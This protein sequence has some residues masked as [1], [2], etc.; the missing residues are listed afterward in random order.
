MVVIEI[1]SIIFECI[2]IQ[3]FYMYLKPIDDNLQQNI[4]FFSNVILPG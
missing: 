1:I 4:E 2:I 3:Q